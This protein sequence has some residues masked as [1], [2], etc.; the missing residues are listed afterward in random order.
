MFDCIV[1]ASRIFFILNIENNIAKCLKMYY[2]DITGLWNMRF[3]HL[4]FQ[5][6]KFSIQKRMVKGLPSTT[7]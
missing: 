2:E 3:G 1:P 5:G 6:L 7:H 4:K